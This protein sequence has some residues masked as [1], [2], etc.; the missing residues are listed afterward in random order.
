MTQ[1]YREI[2]RNIPVVVL[3]DDEENELPDEQLNELLDDFYRYFDLCNEQAF[4]RQNRRVSKE[5]WENWCDGMRS[6]MKRKYFAKAWSRIK[7]KTSDDFQE[8]KLLEEMDF[9]ADPINWFNVEFSLQQKGNA[10]NQT[11]IASR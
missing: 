7:V 3:L 5:T 11:R 1:Q 8:L 6:N 4:L 9:R 10:S 2:I